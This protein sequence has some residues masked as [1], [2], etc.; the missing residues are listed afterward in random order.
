LRYAYH[1][2]S[3]PRSVYL[4]TPSSENLQCGHNLVY[5]QHIPG[6]AKHH[7]FPE[8]LCCIRSFFVILQNSTYRFP[9]NSI[10]SQ[11]VP[12][13]TLDDHKRKKGKPRQASPILRHELLQF[14]QLSSRPNAY[15]YLCGVPISPCQLRLEANRKRPLLQ[16]RVTGLIPRDV[17]QRV[18]SSELAESVVHIF[19]RVKINGQVDHLRLDG[20]ASAVE[21]Q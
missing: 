1:M 20:K 12:F 8:N 16:W 2:R 13:V 18:S 19:V 4:F 14:V 6:R 17:R 21:W 11:K 10:C 9:L 7:P 5:S 15:L 3:E